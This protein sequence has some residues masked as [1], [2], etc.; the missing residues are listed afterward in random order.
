MKGQRQKLLTQGIGHTEFK[1]EPWLF[2]TEIEIPVEWEINTLGPSTEYVGSG[3]T[4][5]GGSRI[6]K[7]SGIPI[8]RSQ[9]VQF[10]GLT[11]KNMAYI[12]QEIH[13]TMSR[14]KL[15][16]VLLYCPLL[17]LPPL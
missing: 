8:I 13:D 1:K 14:T 9:N 7:E 5:K 17:L 3:S 15:Q 2:Q 11:F 4:P 10:E 6:Y 12:T 16:D